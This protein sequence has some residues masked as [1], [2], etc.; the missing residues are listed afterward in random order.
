MGFDFFQGPFLFKSKMKK[1]F[2][3]LLLL[4]CRLLPSNAQTISISA[5]RA[6][7]VGSIV[8]VS[9]IVTNGP[10]LGIIRYIQDGTGGIGVFSNLL[11][12]TVR[13][14]LITVT[15]VTDDY[16]NLL[17]I[18]PV[19][20]FTLNSSGNTLPVPQ[21]V[22]ASLLSEPFE[23]QLV[24]I[25][26]VTFSNPGGVFSGNAT[27]N[28]TANGQPGVIYLRSNSPLVGTT[29]PAGSIT[30]TGICS[31]NNA[32]YQVLP[33]DANDLVPS[34]SIYFTTPLSQVN[35][36]STG[37]DVT[38]Q[39]NI[40][41][42]TFVEYGTT[43]AFGSMSTG[44][45]GVTNHSVSISGASA[46]QV[47]YVKS[48]SVAGTDTAFSGTKIF[49]TAS[50][51]SGIIK[52]YFNRSVDLSVASSPSNHAI[53]LL[54]AIDDT[55]KAYIDRCV[56]TLDI[57]IYNFDNTNTA[58]I[59]QAI[60]DA[61]NRGVQI[62]IISD[63][64][65]N[66]AALASLNGNIPKISSPTVPF[67]YYG[68]M[69]NKFVVIDANAA[70]PNLP[71]VWTGSTNWSSD[72]LY[73][74][75]N[76]V[77][78]FQD[79]SLAVAY[80]M[81]FNEMWGSAGPTPNAANA[82]FGPD[83]SNNTPHE[84]SIGGK[85][86]ENYFS[87]SDNV[88]YEIIRTANTAQ[89]QLFFSTYVFTRYDIAFAIEDRVI[90]GVLAAGIVDDSSNGGGYPFSIMQ[91]VMGNNIELYDHAALPG[92]LHHKYMIVDQHQP[93]FD[94]LVLTGSHNWSSTANSK[95]DENTVIVHDA[96]I[97]NQYYQEF[98]ERFTESGGTLGILENTKDSLV[99]YAI[100]PNP[101]H[102]Q[103]WVAIQ[104]GRSLKC[105]IRLLTVLGQ[106]V[107]QLKWSYD[108]KTNTHSLDVSG[109]PPGLYFVNID[110]G[111]AKTTRKLII[112]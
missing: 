26:N 79:Q 52:T 76:N 2:V 7:P 64:S 33:R 20:V 112:R 28:F 73:I 4:F 63:G 27:L 59:I 98:Y 103:V 16:F 84:F 41:G 13:G 72:Q 95:N 40:A 93:S 108:F 34:G 100:Y 96:D 109:L 97:A 23:S 37:F 30:L 78:I 6:L 9:G 65:N 46:S 66:N 22:P 55:L 15:G 36:T 35:T 19:G 58:A 29:I 51:S 69:H 90:N 61:Y 88:N 10:E 92:I 54:N 11:S 89:G 101:A 105:N 75:A 25:Q 42:S 80:T 71:V 14:D 70:N 57:A 38:W 17:E 24:Q 47:Y 50:L 82:K 102:D 106:E 111:E 8:T 68:I 32:A 110:A 99:A 5:A 107:M 53:R 94:P 56:Y 87:P 1:H 86:V 12:S 83:K 21:I 45:S 3:M 44:A 85:R 91:S 48:Y 62:R 43:P 104:G 31:Q 49:I 81:E 77:I 60:N 74:D 18:N 67:G 39:T